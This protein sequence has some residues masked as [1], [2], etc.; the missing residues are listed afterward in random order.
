MG[1]SL[2]KPVVL[3]TVYDR[4]EHL[5]KC[6]ESLERCKG[7][8]SFV[9]LVGSDAA[10]KQEDKQKIDE[11]RECLLEKSRTHSFEDL[12]LV[13][14]KENVGQL[15]NLM[16]LHELAKREAFQSYVYMEDDVV[17]GKGFLEF[18][19]NGLQMYQEH[20]DVLGVCGYIRPGLPVK[21]DKAFLFDRVSAYGVGGWY[22]K[23]EGCVGYSRLVN[24]ASRVLSS[25]SSYRRKAKFTVNAKSYPFIAEGMY[26]AWDIEMG[27][28]L[29]LENKWFLTP[30]KTLTA[31]RGMDGSGLRSGIDKELQAM[32]PSDECFDIP[33]IGNIQSVNFE[34]VATRVPLKSYLINICIFIIYSYVPKGYSILKKI[35]EVTR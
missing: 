30:P 3:V 25:L 18:M 35:R 8:E 33:E 23:K 12:K 9:V 32:E 27:L 16:T 20:A 6:L 5:K 4:L 11:V 17:V 14:H 29:D 1:Y 13:L 22:N 34:E 10:G 26:K 2:M 31:N 21:Q 19:K 7:S 24:V 15:V 28:F